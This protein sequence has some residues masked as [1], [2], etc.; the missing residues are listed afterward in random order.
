MI[1][2]DEKVGYWVEGEV[3]FG[4]LSCVI[5]C[6]MVSFIEWENIKGRFRERF[7]VDFD[8]LSLRCLWGI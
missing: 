2:F 6:V 5:G 7:W 4:F 1:E 3:I 8:V